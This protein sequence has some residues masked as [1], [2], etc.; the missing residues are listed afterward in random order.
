MS[1]LFDDT[2]RALKI[3][4]LVTDDAAVTIDCIDLM[5]SK[6]KE[7]HGNPQKIVESLYSD[8]EA[9]PEH[10]S[11]DTMPSAANLRKT[12]NTRVRSET[13]NHFTIINPV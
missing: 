12:Y 8:L 3:A 7:A 6:L 5:W 10:K 11:T 2:G 4:K 13:S 9:I 1:Y